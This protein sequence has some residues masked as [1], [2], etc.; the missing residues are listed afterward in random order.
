MSMITRYKR[1]GGFLQLLCLIETFGKQK[2]EKFL[3]MIREENPL[4]ADAIEDRLIT[5]DRMFSWPS[6][7]LAEIMNRVPTKNVAVALY[8]LSDE[9]RDQIFSLISHSEKRKLEGLMNEQKPSE[10]E[11]TASLLKL[12]EATREMLKSSVLRVDQTD[13][14]MSIPENIEERLVETSQTVEP[15]SQ[16]DEMWPPQKMPEREN[17]PDQ[18]KNL[19]SQASSRG[20][21]LSANT[22]IVHLNSSGPAS[23]DLLQHKL[24]QLQKENQVL[25][26]ENKNLRERLANIKKL[27]A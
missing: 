15:K 8:G 7:T 2:Q 12:I 13:E 1:A 27:A 19:A 6:A 21:S 23:P 5:I 26:N 10:G 9:R 17:G 20:A 18:N 3:T 25:K 11:I 22:S 4:W 16:S 14:R 24:V